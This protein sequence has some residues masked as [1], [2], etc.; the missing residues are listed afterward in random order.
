[1]VIAG[2]SIDDASVRDVHDATTASGYAGMALH[3]RHQIAQP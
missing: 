2:Q 3:G 1:L